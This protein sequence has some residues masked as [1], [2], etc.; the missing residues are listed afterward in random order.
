VIFLAYYG[1]TAA[2]NR[3][4]VNPWLATA[5]A[6]GLYP[7]L[8]GIMGGIDAVV[9]PQRERQLADR[10]HAEIEGRLRPLD[11]VRPAQGSA[12]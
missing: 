7:I 9:L 4:E 6:L 3:G 12:T 1:A 2:L 5:I 8:W 10:L 11:A